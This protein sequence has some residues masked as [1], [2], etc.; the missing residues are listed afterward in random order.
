MIDE[1]KLEHIRVCLEDEVEA[2]VSTG[3]PDVRLLHEALPGIDRSDVETGTEFLGHELSMPVVIAGMTGGHE[4]A[5]EI[6]ASLAEAAQRAGVAVGVGS[7]RAALEDRD[8]E[9]TYSVVAERAPDALKIANVG[10]P[11]LVRGYGV[12]EAERAVEMVDAGALAVHLNFT[13]EAVQ[14]EGETEAEGLL[15]RLGEIC[16][17]LSVPVVVKETGAG[18]SGGTARR[19]SEAGVSAIDV[20][21]LGGT[22]WSAVEMHRSER[23]GDTEGVRLGNEFREWGIPTVQ[24]VVE[25]SPVDADLMASGGVRGGLDVAKT[26]ALGAD[27]AGAALPFLAP[28]TEGADEVEAT[29]RSWGEGLRAAM[30][31]TGSGDID[32]LGTAPLTITGRS[33]QLLEQRGYSLK[34]FA[35]R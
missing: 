1:R 30:F 32:E 33:A 18:V 12:E 31:L 27:V 20:S 8:L 22:S 28:A 29:L 3:F 21:G 7:Q 25:C 35:R 2:R 13:Q 34:N 23:K 17:G 19:L 26:L 4:R 16:S 6:N 11:Q 14:L 24:S 9:H 5:R 15:E 10:G